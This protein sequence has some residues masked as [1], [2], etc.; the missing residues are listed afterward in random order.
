M[1]VSVAAT[2]NVRTM[3]LDAWLARATTDER[4]R[5]RIAI[6]P[7]RFDV[8]VIPEGRSAPTWFE[9]VTVTTSRGAT[10]DATIRD[11]SGPA[12]DTHKAVGSEE[13]AVISGQIRDVRGAPLKGVINVYPARG[14]LTSPAR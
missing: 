12:A 3:R 10:L 4:G 2:T 8:Q 11:A 6:N 13:A 5:F 14:N 1:L 7:G 9:G